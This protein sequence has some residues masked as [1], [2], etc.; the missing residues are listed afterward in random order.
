MPDLKDEITR[1]MPDDAT[2]P[3]TI[4]GTP[5]LKAFG[6]F[7]CELE[8]DDGYAYTAVNA[9]TGKWQMLTNRKYP[10]QKSDVEEMAMRIKLSRVA[11][12]GRLE[13]ERPFGEQIALQNAHEI[14]YEV[15]GCILPSCGCP[16]TSELI[17]FAEQIMEAICC[18]A[19]AITGTE[20]GAGRALAYL[21]PA[22]IAKLGRLNDPYNVALYPEM[23]CADMAHLPIVVAVSTY[24][25]QQAL[26]DEHI[27]GL[28]RAMLEA[29]I[30][31]RPLN[32]APRDR[33]SNS[34]DSRKQPPDIH[35]CSHHT[36]IADTLRRAERKGALL[37]SYQI[38][39]IDEA[40]SFHAAAQRAYKSALPSDA[41]PRLMEAVGG[42]AFH[43]EASR[44][45]AH[46][47]AKKLFDENRRLFRGFAGC[48]AVW[49]D[50]GAKRH[51]RNIRDIADRLAMILRGESFRAKAAELL[52]W[53]KANYSADVSKLDL[54][55]LIPAS[56]YE[57]QNADAQKEAMRIQANRIYAAICGLRGIRDGAE[58]ERLLRQQRYLGKDPA[59]Q[60]LRNETSGR[61]DSIWRVASKLLTNEGITGG[62]NQHERII[63]ECG[64]IS[65]Q[66]AS[67]LKRGE[68]DCWVEADSDKER[69]CATPK[70]LD[71]Q[72]YDDLWD[73]GIPIILVTDA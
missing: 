40:T 58:K 19:V 70:D 24:A 71:S 46:K 60:A 2:M 32:P 43:N 69:L 45:A 15:L 7:L 42:M 34:V 48:P 68:L 18:R 65:E 64:A 23:A 37:P 62:Y 35:V 53:V 30:I 44:R 12:A 52:S 28:S 16:M 10:M 33:S 67:F 22:V 11:G 8:A 17:S 54:G 21:V 3:E 38:L 49:L 29:G 66:A 61:L 5:I 39:I 27:P 63:R 73:K 36:L 6:C 50:D 26:T 55:K 13:V 57:A 51:L 41:A 47:T 20:N 56:L 72:L 31:K 1:I 59:G 14:L 4:H 25:L 9:V